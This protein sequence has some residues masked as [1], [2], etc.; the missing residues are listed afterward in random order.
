MK[1]FVRED[2]EIL[3][4]LQGV[5]GAYAYFVFQLQ[6]FERM[7]KLRLKFRSLFGVKKI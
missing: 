7:N 6:G 2:N 5:T 4:G 3:M 1:V